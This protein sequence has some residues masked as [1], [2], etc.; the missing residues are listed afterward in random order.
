MTSPLDQDWPLED[1][2]RVDAC[3]YCGS[4]K[5][6]L[7]YKNVQDWSF[8]CAQGKWDYWDCESCKSL[9]LDPRPNLSTIGTAYAKY[10]THGS[11]KKASF[12]Q[13]LKARLRNECL[14]QKL[15]SSIAPRLN[16]PKLLDGFVA[17][18]GERVA[19]PFGWATLASRP[20]GKFMDVGCGAGVAVSFAQQIGWDAMGLEIDPSAVR[21]AQR[22]GLNIVQGTFEQL[23]QYPQQFDCIMCSHVL[24]HVHEPRNLLAHLKA[25]LKPG[26]VLLISLPNSL[27]PMRRYFGADWRG[28][29]APRHLSIPSELQLLKLLVESGFSMRS[30]S[31]TGIETASESFR[32]KRR[33]LTL[34]R[35]DIAMASKLSI[36]SI[37]TVV[38]ND[39][40]QLVGE[41][42]AVPSV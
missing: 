5:R 33:G 22:T 37:E 26:G 8:Q 30:I 2:E 39:L 14:N 25:A 24:E 18:I 21:E 17:M 23:M 34:S 15:S 32:I 31:G 27:S 1:L 41:V 28:L 10:Y 35:Q 4:H 13:V 11:G 40:M 42:P 12:L 6:A 36:P 7:A 29:E 38:D 3:P 19:I 20:K 16:L 9:Y